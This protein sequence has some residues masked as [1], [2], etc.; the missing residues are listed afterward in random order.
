MDLDR[1]FAAVRRIP[2]TSGTH[3]NACTGPDMSPPLARPR[4]P[5]RV[6]PSHSG[7]TP[8][9]PSRDKPHPRTRVLVPPPTSTLDR[10]P[11]SLPV[12]Q[13]KR[14]IA[15]SWSP[16]FLAPACSRMP[17]TTSSRID[18]PS[19]PSVARP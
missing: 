8:H 15:V 11:E 14:T 17:H 13:N 4:M 5:P 19:Q 2:E 18:S 10:R 16:L 9:T 12:T 1:P 3:H 7:N 6:L